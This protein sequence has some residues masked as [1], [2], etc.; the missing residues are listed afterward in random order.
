MNSTAE[1]EPKRRLSRIGPAATP[2]DRRRILRTLFPATGKRSN[3]R[4]G[5]MMA[6]SVVIALMGLSANS[7]AVVIGAMLIAPLMA[8]VLGLS[9]A[10]VVALGRH[11]ARAAATVVVA[12]A[13]AIALSWAIT[14]LLP[15]SDR[16]LTSEALSRTS[17]DLRD[18]F[19]A[20]AA[21]AAGAYA[22]AREDL[23]GALPGVAV[24][25]ALV[26][27]LATVGFTLGAGRRDLAGGALLLFVANL[28][29]IVLAGVVVFLI[30]GL[31]PRRRLAQR[32]RSVLAAVAVVV[33]ATA[34][35]AVPLAERSAAAVRHARRVQQIN[36][37]V[38]AWLTTTDLVLTDVQVAGD[39]VAI[40]VSGPQSPPDTEPLRQ[41]LVAYLGSGAAVR[42]RWFQNGS[43][44]MTQASQ[45][46]SATIPATTDLLRPLVDAWLATS[47][48]GSGLFRISGISTNQG[49]V[50]VDVSGPVAP[51]PAA[52]LA[53]QIS[54][55]LGT[56]EKVNIHWTQT[57]T[58]TVAPAASDRAARVRA[59]VNTWLLAHPGVDL[60][61]VSVGTTAV[62]VDLAA[63]APP[64]TT[65]FITQ[66]QAVTD[67]GGIQIRLA[68]L[69]PLASSPPQTSTSS[70][71]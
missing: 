29:A 71:P 44:T 9:A 30:T 18:L 12:S 59:A 26:P 58:T 19:V 8:P 65:A 5:V 48:K 62:T 56:S 57:S 70:R 64:D 41:A 3:V 6:L 68:P 28:V 55:H 25:V 67:G 38:T 60:L 39:Q 16:V 54:A 53:Q 31:A 2:E 15:I 24:A 7:A 43:A 37:A 1:A 45:A 36:T 63:A 32:S 46:S 34:V 17:P 66:L 33:I 61:G 52:D 40:D 47:V 21:G 27:P 22:T 49:T 11:M 42:V 4:F 23:S 20:L 14:L 50:T 51:P 69:E 10:I 35:V 13:G